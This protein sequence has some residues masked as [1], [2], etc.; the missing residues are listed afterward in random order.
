M[1]SNECTK[2][3][4]TRL[5]LPKDHHY[6]ALCVGEAPEEGY[7][8]DLTRGSFF[9]AG[10]PL[11]G[12]LPKPIYQNQN[13]APKLNRART[14]L[15]SVFS[16][17]FHLMTFSYQKT[18]NFKNGILIS[19]DVLMSG[20]KCCKKNIKEKIKWKKKKWLVGPRKRLKRQ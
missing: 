16:R 5:G 6:T 7:Y 3:I 4:R 14:L 9:F 11:F 1:A 15:R 2:Y 20:V 17:F 12:I 19:A 18:N 8:H 13:S 10:A